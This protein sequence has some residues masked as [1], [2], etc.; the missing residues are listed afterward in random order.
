ME[1][2][3]I[4]VVNMIFQS[5]ENTEMIVGFKEGA[6]AVEEDKKRKAAG[7]PTLLK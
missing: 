2:A 3:G 7:G 6:R 5:R 4:E 1:R